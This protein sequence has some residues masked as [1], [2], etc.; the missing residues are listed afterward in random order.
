MHRIVTFIGGAAPGPPMG[1]MSDP[2]GVALSGRT[3]CRFPSASWPAAVILFRDNQR[4]VR[5]F[6]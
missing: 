4:L 6:P 5:R 1:P 2:N 3:G